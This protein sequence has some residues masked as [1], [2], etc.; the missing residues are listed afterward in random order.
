M[1][2]YLLYFFRYELQSPDDSFLTCTSSGVYDKP[3]PVCQRIQCKVISNEQE[4]CKLRSK[5]T[6]TFQIFYFIKLFCS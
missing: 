5:I 1:L 4:R 3:P 6:S 2:K